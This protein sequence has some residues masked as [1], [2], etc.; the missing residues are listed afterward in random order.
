MPSSRPTLWLV[1]APTDPPSL[2]QFPRH[3]PHN[4][5]THPPGPSRSIPAPSPASSPATLASGDFHALRCFFRK[6]M[7]APRSGSRFPLS[8]TALPGGIVNTTAS[9]RYSR[10]QGQR[11]QFIRLYAKDRTVIARVHR[12]H[13]QHWHHHIVIRRR[14]QVALLHLIR[15][16]DHMSAGRHR[17]VRR[18]REVARQVQM[19]LV[20]FEAPVITTHPHMGSPC[21]LP[22]LPSAQFLRLRDGQD[23]IT[24]RSF[25]LASTTVSIGSSALASQPASRPP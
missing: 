19:P 11:R 22:T 10:G 8:T 14:D 2:P 17:P 23:Q 4:S 1:F 25:T 7:A 3:A 18:D 21:P 6:K 12:Q 20:A 9:P 24:I 5:H 15:C 16:R 13:F